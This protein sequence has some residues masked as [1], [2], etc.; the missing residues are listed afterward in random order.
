MYYTREQEEEKMEGV[1][2]GA[3]FFSRNTNLSLKI[4]T[5]YPVVLLVCVGS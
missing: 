5:Q 1:V 3:A 2:I 4:P